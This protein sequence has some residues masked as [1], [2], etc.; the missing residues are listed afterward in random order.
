[1]DEAHRLAGALG[2]FGLPEGTRIERELETRYAGG[3]YL[4][5]MDGAELAE[6]AG[7]LRADGAHRAR[8][9]LPRLRRRRRR[10]R[11]EAV[12]RAELV[13]RIY[14]RLERVRG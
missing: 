13:A 2:T 10:L 7:R 3:T 6:V 8:D 11:G 5:A 1:V 9:R 12:R 14:N 4:T